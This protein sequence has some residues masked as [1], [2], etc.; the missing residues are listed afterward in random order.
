MTLSYRTRKNL[1]TL[2][3]ALLVLLLVAAVV[4]LI[5][6]LFAERYVIITD[7]GAKLDFSNALRDPD[8]EVVKPPQAEETIG[9]YYNEGNDVV[10]LED[11][12]V[13][14]AGFYVDIPTL[15]EGLD[16]IR[17]QLEAIESPCAV[18]LDMKSIHGSYFYNTRIPGTKTVS[19]EE[20]DIDALEKLIADLKSRDFYLIARVPAFRDANYVLENP[21]SAIPGKDEN[22]EA[23]FPWPGEDSCYWLDPAGTETMSLLSQTAGEL[24]NMGFDEVVF[25]DFF[26]PDTDEIYYPAEPSR[27]DVLEKTAENLVASCSTSHFAVS[28]ETPDPTLR[29]PN[30]R[31]RLY[32]ADVEAPDVAKT[33]AMISVPDPLVNLVF[34]A[35]TNDT[36][37]DTYGVMRPLSNAK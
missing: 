25:T 15:L 4:W 21:N 33:A 14:L 30:G 13:Q 10:D 5:W 31:S 34:L 23:S 3:I 16:P 11:K 35:E 8:G 36:R 9:I 32:L 17:Q 18:M 26:F 37:Y 19:D 29:L 2:G 7:D 20:L 24:R 22:G 6:V 12:L 27:A 28:F 1:H